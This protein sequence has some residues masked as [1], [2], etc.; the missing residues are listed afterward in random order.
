M[1]TAKE[2]ENWIR[3]EFLQKKYG[4]VFTK[5]KLGVQSGGEIEYDAVSED[6]KIVGIISTSPGMTADG[7]PD[8]DALSKIREKILW[9]VSLNEKPDTIAIAFTEKSMGE[10]LKQE[11]Q[12][13]RLP[14]YVKMLPVKL[15]TKGG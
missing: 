13:G 15:P 7:K 1:T 4:Q 6:G 8:P 9:A 14:K 11:K 10:L 3:N 2:V 5:R 12:N